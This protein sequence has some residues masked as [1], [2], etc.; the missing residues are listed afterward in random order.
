MASRNRRIISCPR[1]QWTTTRSHRPT[2]C[3][4]L[5]ISLISTTQ[6]VAVVADEL[7]A[8]EREMQQNEI[9]VVVNTAAPASNPTPKSASSA[10]VPSLAKESDELASYKAGAASNEVQGTPRGVFSF[11]I[12]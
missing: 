11:N 3:S 2:L 12:L 1:A 10:A 5:Y 8:V 7:A 9:E 6:Q 4:Y